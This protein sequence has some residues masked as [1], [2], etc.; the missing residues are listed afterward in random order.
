[1]SLCHHTIVFIFFEFDSSPV[2]PP[3]ALIDETVTRAHSN[4]HGFD[5]RLDNTNEKNRFQLCHTVI[6][7]WSQA[8]LATAN[9]YVALSSRDRFHFFE[10]DSSPVDP[11]LA[12]IDETVTRAHSSAHGFDLRLDNTNEKIVFNYLTLSSHNGIR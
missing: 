5:L 9:Q 7:Q 12:L 4:A 1:M 11:P 3:L 6:T 8:V 2:D 10:F